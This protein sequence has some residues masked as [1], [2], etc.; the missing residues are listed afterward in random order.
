MLMHGFPREAAVTVDI[1][2]VRTNFR[3][4]DVL[5]IGLGGGSLVRD[6][7]ARIGPDSVG[8]EITSRALVFGG[9]DAD[10]D[11]HRRGGRPRRH[12]RSQP[13]RQSRPA[14]DRDR[15]RHHA[16]DG[17][18]R[19]RPHEDERGGRAG[20]PGRRRRDSRVSATCPPRPP[21]CGRSR[22]PSPM[23]SAP[24]SRRSAAR[25]TASS[26][27]TGLSRDG[28]AGRSQRRG[29]RAGA[30]RRCRCPAVSRSSRSRKCRSP[31]C[32]QRHAH[33]R[34]GGRRSRAAVT[35]HDSG[36]DSISRTFAGGAAFLG[37]G[38]GGDPYVGRL[39]AQAAMRRGQARSRSSRSER[40]SPTMRW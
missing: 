33:P 32:R 26:R 14:A 34:Q 2:G 31:I 16:P 6:D 19:R 21:C 3:M 39:M 12:R 18:R 36:R 7:G 25:S 22:Q 24:R 40:V 20:D 27:W 8:Y 35:R 13:R 17:R 23:R 38:G 4:P 11:R 10:D 15:A 29:D 5:S 1:G 9:D 37:T 30:R 28:G